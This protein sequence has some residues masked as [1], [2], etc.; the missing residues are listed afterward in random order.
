[1]VSLRYVGGGP[2]SPETLTSWRGVQEP[3]EVGVKLALAALPAPC[4]LER[5]VQH[6]GL[7]CHGRPPR[8]STCSGPGGCASE[9]GVLEQ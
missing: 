2:R 6:P 7:G 1:M 8:V 5:P 3:P 4:P 9:C